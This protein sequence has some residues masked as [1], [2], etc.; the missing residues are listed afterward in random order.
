MERH[1]HTFAPGYVPPGQDAAVAYAGVDLRFQNPYP[2][3][4]TLQVRPEG[5]RLVCRLLAP[6]LLPVQVAVRR[7]TLDRFAPAPAPVRPGMGARRSRW[8]PLGRDGIRV[9]VVRDFFEGS[10]RIRREAV[11]DDTYRPLSRAEWTLP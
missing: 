10:R 4:L 11:S 2:W 3:P 9:A 8:H 1:A 5:H 6:Q 7:E